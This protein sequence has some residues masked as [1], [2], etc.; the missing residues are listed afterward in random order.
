MHLTKEDLKAFA[1]IL[2]ISLEPIRQDIREL[3]Q[4]VAVLKQEMIV[5]KQDIANM[6][7]D[8][9]ELKQEMIVVKQDIA[10]MKQDISGLKQETYT[11]RADLTQVRLNQ[12]VTVLPRLGTIESCYLDTY[13]RYVGGIAQ[14]DQLQQD[15]DILKSTVAI[16]SQKLESI[17]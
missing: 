12:E 15:V 4:D 11:L 8:I 5:V 3:K 9:A 1:E 7:Q 13:R 16:H 14:L 2:D 17:A 10:N 6:K